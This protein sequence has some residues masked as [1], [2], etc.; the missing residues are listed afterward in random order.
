MDCDGDGYPAGVDCDDANAAI[1]PGAREIPGNAVD[2]DCDPIESLPRLDSSIVYSFTFVGRLTRFTE[3]YIRP[4][5]SG[6]TIRLGCGGR[7]CP[8]HV[9][10]RQVKANLRRLN[11]SSL[12]RRAKLRPGAQIEIRVTK[13]GTVGIVRRLTVRAGKRPTQADLCLPPGARRPSRCPL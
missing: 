12:V 4:A 2:E 1:N 8:F 10:K 3:L 13:P 11:L 6:S 9:K 5:R 7:G